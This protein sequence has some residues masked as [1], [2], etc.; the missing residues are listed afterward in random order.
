MT[1]FIPHA[2]L[3][4]PSIIQQAI[5]ACSHGIQETSV[6]ESDKHEEGHTDRTSNGTIPSKYNET[7][8]SIQEAQ[9]QRVTSET[10]VDKVIGKMTQGDVKAL[11]PSQA[12]RRKHG[13]KP[14]SAPL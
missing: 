1:Y 9:S 4:H 13:I 2:I 14:Q 11:L 12:R 7:R 3:I 5:A 6:T 10:N 8:R